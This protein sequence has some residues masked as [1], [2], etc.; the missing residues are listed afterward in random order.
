MAGHFG[1]DKTLA[2]VQENFFWPK[3]A[4]DVECFVKCCRICQIT[5][6]HSKNTGLYTL[7]PVP[8]APWENISL[9]FALGLPRT[10]RNKDSII[11]V[12]DRFSKMAHFI[13][14]NK[15]ADASH[16]AD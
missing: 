1:G 6:S 15:T 2:L 4:H 13:S 11:M 5:K 16:I 12:V 9:D 14:C 3:L 7:L 8:K 10:Q